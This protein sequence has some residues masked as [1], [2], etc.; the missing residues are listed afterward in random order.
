MKFRFVVEIEVKNDALTREAGK[1]DITVML[2]EHLEENK[3]AT[4]PWVVQTRYIV[5][6]G[7]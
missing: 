4:L 5:V 3:L 2:Q 1:S 6:K 7:M